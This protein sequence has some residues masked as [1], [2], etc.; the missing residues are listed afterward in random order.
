MNR[1]IFGLGLVF[2]IVLNVACKFSGKVETL[3]F[4]EAIPCAGNTWIVNEPGLERKMVGKGGVHNWTSPDAILRTYFKTEKP[5]DISIESI[6]KMIASDQLDTTSVLLGSNLSNASIHD[7]KNLPLILFGGGFKHG[8]H[9]VF[10]QKNNKPLSNLFLSMLHK[11][12]IN[13]ESFAYSNG[14]LTW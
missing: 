13:A 9:V 5:L 2:L 14:T 1:S 7:T 3:Q 12:G 11:S 10:D 8:S 4:S 6:D